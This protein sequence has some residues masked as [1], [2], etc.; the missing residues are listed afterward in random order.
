MR[1][2]STIKNITWIDMSKPDDDDIK[3]LKSKYKIHPLTIKAIVSSNRYPD[4]D[5]FKNYMFMIL[6]YPHPRENND[7]DIREINIVAGTDFMITVHNEDIPLLRQVLESYANVQIKKSENL[8]KNSGYLLF[9]ILNAFI[10]DNLSKINDIAQRVDELEKRLFTGQERQLI[11]EISTLKMQIIDYCRIAEPQRSV[12]QSLGDTSIKFFSEEYEHYFS[13]IERGHQRVE[14][15]IQSAKNTV[16]ALEKTNN[17]ILNVKLNET[18]KILTVF[19]VIFLPLT[20][21]ASIWGMNTNYLPFQSTDMDFF[22]IA[23]IL[24]VTAFSM[25][26]YFRHKKWL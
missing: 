26:M 10:K 18:I 9:M 16:E 20:L 23:T 25:I 19:S 15:T 17:I 11:E 2:V 22:I 24:V 6:H 13:I 5:H 21:L 7:I 8:E 4:L 12:F 1:T 3:F 14:D